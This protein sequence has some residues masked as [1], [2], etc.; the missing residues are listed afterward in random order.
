[1]GENMTMYKSLYA[2]TFLVLF[3]TVARAENEQEEGKQLIARAVEL[4]DI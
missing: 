3:A 2:I 4:S 1:M